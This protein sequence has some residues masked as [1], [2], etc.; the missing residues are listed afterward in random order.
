[1]INIKLNTNMKFIIIIKLTLSS[2]SLAVINSYDYHC[3]YDN[4]KSLTLN[5]HLYL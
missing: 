5:E 2:F 1:M 4:D 3:K